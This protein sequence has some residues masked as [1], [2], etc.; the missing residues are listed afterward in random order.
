M[1]RQSIQPI[2]HKIPVEDDTALHKKGWVVQRIGWVLMFVFLIAALLGLFG[3]G[4]L[5]AKTIEAGSIT[6]KYQRFCRYEHGMQL[7]L[8]SAGEGITV[9]ALPQQYLKKFKVDKI[10]PSPSSE[11]ASPGYINYMFAGQQND[12]VSFYLLPSERGG[13]GGV[14]KV[15]NQTVALQHYI[16]P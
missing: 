13:A 11:V 6:V 14:I 5:S 9:V 1:V 12:N 4:P 16:Y 15:N 7:K 2:A 3:E 8:L 10:V